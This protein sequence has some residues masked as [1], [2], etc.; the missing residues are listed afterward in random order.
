MLHIAAGEEV[1]TYFY[2]VPKADATFGAD[3][4][5]AKVFLYYNDPVLGK[6]EVTYNNNALP[7]YSDDSSEFWVYYASDTAYDAGQIDETNKFMKMY[8]KDSKNPLVP[9]E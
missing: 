6:Q 3:D 7:G 8:Y 2:I 1:Y 4:I 9:V 5:V